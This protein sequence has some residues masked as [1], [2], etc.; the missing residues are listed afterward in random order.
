MRRS[1]ALAPLGL[2]LI[3][4]ISLGCLKIEPCLK[5][6]AA[7]SEKDDDANIVVWRVNGYTLI[8]SASRVLNG[9]TYHI[10]WRVLDEENNTVWEG[11]AQVNRSKVTPEVPG[12]IYCDTDE[13]GKISIGDLI[14]VKVDE[15]GFYRIEA[16]YDGKNCWISSL[17]HF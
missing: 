16:L 2:I 7:V 15:D 14:I 3:L 11:M 13:D 9:F 12:V 4:M 8:G 17:E 1:S 6:D 10:T 5:I